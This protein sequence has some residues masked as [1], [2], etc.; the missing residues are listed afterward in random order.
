MVSEIS[1]LWG[2]EGFFALFASGCLGWLLLGWILASAGIVF[3]SPGLHFEICVSLRGEPETQG[4]RHS[5]KLS[6]LKIEKTWELDW[7]LFGTHF[8]AVAS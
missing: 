5:K 7:E 2:D 6:N 4:V 3:V 8:D 1:V